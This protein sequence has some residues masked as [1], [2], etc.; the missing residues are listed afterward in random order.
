MGLTS[1]STGSTLLNSDL[2]EIYDNSD[3]VIAIAR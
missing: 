1:K 3:Y 2:A